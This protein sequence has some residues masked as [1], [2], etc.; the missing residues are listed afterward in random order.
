M[1]SF[2]KVKT[3]I[4]DIPRG[5]FIEEKIININYISFIERFGDKNW[6]YQIT[7]SSGEKHLVYREYL[8]DLFNDFL[9][10]KG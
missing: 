4:A 9:N 7:M 10:E 5:I 1:D 8:D 2:R 3:Y 6:A